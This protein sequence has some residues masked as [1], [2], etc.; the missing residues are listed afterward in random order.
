MH[1]WTELDVF[2]KKISLRVSTSKYNRMKQINDVSSKLQD[3]WELFGPIGPDHIEIWSRLE[4]FGDKADIQPNE[5]LCAVRVALFGA[6]AD[7]PPLW[8]R[9][10]LLRYLQQL[11]LSTSN[12]RAA[13]LFALALWNE[14][15]EDS[16]RFNDLLN[17]IKAVKVLDP[18][19][20]EAFKNR[21]FQRDFCIS[22]GER[23]PPDV[24]LQPYAENCTQIFRKPSITMFRSI[25]R[26]RFP[27][28]REM[29]RDVFITSHR[30]AL[31]NGKSNLRSDR[32]KQRLN[33]INQDSRIGNRLIDETRINE[34]GHA[35]LSLFFEESNSALLPT[36]EEQELIVEFF[37]RIIGSSTQS[38]NRRFSKL[39]DELQMLLKRWENGRKLNWAFDVVDSATRRQFDDIKAE[40]WLK[41]REYWQEKWS[42]G[43]VDKIQIFM[44]SRF[45]SE[46]RKQH[47]DILPLYGASV[48]ISALVITLILPG[49]KPV[50]AIEMS[51]NGSLRIFSMHAFPKL[52]FHNRSELHY[53][54]VKDIVIDDIRAFA[55]RHNRYWT[56]KADEAIQSLVNYRI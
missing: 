19:V 22:I 38:H 5:V 46:Y 53:D 30:T 3:K 44:P 39:D 47:P 8:K 45:L 42:N 11:T 25:W 18:S 29:M 16:F 6:N 36:K 23:V 20:N 40:Q 9:L 32:L 37:E 56:T 7:C 2:L 13:I 15:P 35:I 54:D 17:S 27:Q 50:Q 14:W 10:G 51:G 31:E 49:S 12:R 21:Y 48:G 33:F 43:Y 4:R 24:L 34:F 52:D 26:A 55:I 28:Y 1:S 41:R